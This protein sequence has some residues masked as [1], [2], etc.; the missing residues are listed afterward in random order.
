MFIHSFPLIKWSL[1]KCHLITK[2]CSFNA[3]KLCSFVQV[4]KKY[5]YH[6]IFFFYFII[7]F[8]PFFFGLPLSN[9]YHISLSLPLKTILIQHY[10]FRIPHHHC[11]RE[12]YIPA[13]NCFH[14]QC[15]LSLSWNGLVRMMMMMI[16]K[17]RRGTFSTIEVELVTLSWLSCW[18]FQTSVVYYAADFII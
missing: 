9:L 11:Q 5:F 12:S 17:R 3:L 13:L 6:F 15:P 2:Q 18:V 1:I 8:F 7:F 4:I 14:T 10:I 16:R